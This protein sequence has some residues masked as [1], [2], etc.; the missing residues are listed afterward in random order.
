[1]KHTQIILL[2]LLILNFGCA[3]IIRDDIELV[4]ILTEPAGALVKGGPETCHTPCDMELERKKEYNLVITKPGY[5][6]E[7]V[8]LSGSSL[9]GWLW[10]NLAFLVGAPIGVI[11][12]FYSGKA[13]DYD[14]EEITLELKKNQ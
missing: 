10:G 13:W 14:P 9:D 6:T 1:M 8:E 3:T 12:D 7:R 2:A 4:P 5:K 11:W